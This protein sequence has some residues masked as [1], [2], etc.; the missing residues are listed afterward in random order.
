MT[1]A[2]PDVHSRRPATGFVRPTV[3]LVWWNAGAAVLDAFMLRA[4][5]PPEEQPAILVSYLQLREWQRWQPRLPYRQWIL[6][7]GVFT[8]RTQGREIDVDAYADACLELMET[9][10]TLAEIISVDTGAYE[11]GNWRPTARNTERLWN[12]GVPAIPAFHF[13]EPWPVLEGYAR[14][15]PKV[16]IGG[17]VGLAEPIKVRYA[18]ECFARVWPK[19]I[20]GLGVGGRKSIM[21]VPWHSVDSTNWSTSAQRHGNWVHYGRMSVRKWAGVTLDAEVQYF[22]DLEKLARFR[23]RREMAT[24]EAHLEAWKGEAA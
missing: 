20:H 16:A 15:Y 22:I 23:W 2:T 18:K 6:D 4:E 7:S 21:A 12:R 10:P 13:K 19:P 24:L 3:Y 5:R 9:D 8:A 1:I 11:E 14:E 17:L